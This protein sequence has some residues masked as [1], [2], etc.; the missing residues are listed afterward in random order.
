MPSPPPLILAN[1]GL[2]EQAA[3]LLGRVS[4][5][6]Y[7][8]GTAEAKPV[9]PHFRHVLEHY[10]CFLGGWAAGRVDY[11][12]RARESA[13][14]TRR[15]SALDRV[16]ELADGLA[17][18]DASRLED[19]VEVRLE[20]G[21]GGEEQQWSRSTVRRELQFL[22]SHTIHHYAL[23]GLLLARL[24]IDPGETFGVAP[25]TLKHWE[26]NAACAPQPG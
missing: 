20:C 14:E 6:A 3:D 21:L 16:R 4:D 13:L 18:L 22:L 26:R 2:L 15:Q 17:G 12:A 11:D 19:A 7:G 1:L 23:I 8:A 5:H 10:S 9:G 25:S 24:G